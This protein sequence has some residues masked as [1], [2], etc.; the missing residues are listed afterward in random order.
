MKMSLAQFYIET[1]KLSSGCA[2][3]CSFINDRRPRLDHTRRL[4]FLASLYPNKAASLPMLGHPV[5]FGKRLSG[6]KL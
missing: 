5:E 4:S 6:D 2:V 1:L 3:D